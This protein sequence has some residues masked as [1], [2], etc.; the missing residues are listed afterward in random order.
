MSNTNQY[1]ISFDKLEALLKDFK[2]HSSMPGN[3][4]FKLKGFIFTPGIEKESSIKDGLSTD[5]F[6]DCVF[7]F[8]IYSQKESVG[9]DGDVTSQNTNAKYLGC[10]YPPPCDT[11][12]FK[13]DCYG[14]SKK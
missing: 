1:F 5:K 13:N 6:K 14:N 9:N 11:F 7:P 4:K 3:P 2:K 8:P 12:S 10:P